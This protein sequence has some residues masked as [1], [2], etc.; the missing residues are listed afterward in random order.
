MPDTDK[1]IWR[2]IWWCLVQ[3]DCLVSLCYGRPQNMQVYPF[4]SLLA[5][6]S[7]ALITPYRN[8]DDCDVPPL[9]LEDFDS[10]VTEKEANVVM[11]QA[12]LC[13]IVSDL[14]RVHFSV[15]ATNASIDR[16]GALEAVD[17][18]LAEWL[19]NLPP[20]LGDR[21][22]KPTADKEQSWALLPHL[23]YNSVLIQF[24]RP[25][26]NTPGTTPGWE[27][28]GDKEICAEAA[29]NIIQI[30]AQLDHTSGIRYCCFWAPNTLFTAMLQVS[31]QLKCN[32]PILAL[33]SKEKY[34]SGLHSLRKLTRYWLFATSVLK[35]FE[36][37]SI[38]TSQGLTGR[39]PGSSPLG[40]QISSEQ[41]SPLATV[42]SVGALSS[43]TAPPIPINPDGSQQQGMDWVQLLSYGNPNVANMHVERNRWQNSMEE[44]QSLY[45]SDPLANIRLEDS[46]GQF[47]YDWQPQ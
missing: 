5:V 37:N 32:N 22:R 47:Q 23:I 13:A 26:A 42:T 3:F 14:V 43:S 29:S 40:G 11:Q 34:E 45:W 39:C 24:H 1:R 20:D 15:K 41:E 10:S 8:L 27:T 16:R 25:F 38:R 36:S 31:G 44:W 33:R 6:I 4:P 19:V 21:Y 46:F 12:K 35:L 17:Q 30:F 7:T 28:S 18:A 2:M 9:R